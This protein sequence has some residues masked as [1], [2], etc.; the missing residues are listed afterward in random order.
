MYLHVIVFDTVREMRQ[1]VNASSPV[2]QGRRFHGICQT[3]TRVTFDCH[4]RARTH[5]CMGRVVFARRFCSAEVVSHEMTHAALAWV[6][7]NGWDL[8]TLQED[9]VSGDGRRMGAVTDAEEAVCYA[10]GRMVNQAARRF[11]R[12]GLY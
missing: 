8:R 9:D 2:H 4:N 10:V 11:R 3:W 6:R 12:A 5:A 7:R 1:F